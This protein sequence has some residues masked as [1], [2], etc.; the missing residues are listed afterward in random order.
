ME[1]KR[2]SGEVGR[3]FLEK[4]K[5]LFSERELKS[6]VPRDIAAWSRQACDEALPHRIADPCKNDWYGAG[7]LSHR[8]NARRTESEYHARRCA[9]QFRRESLDAPSVRTGPTIVDLQIAT[10][11]PTVL[12][13]ALPE[14]R[15]PSLRF[16]IV[17]GEAAKNAYASHPLGLLRARHQRPSRRPAYQ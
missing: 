16:W 11:A 1:E 14:C 10:L 5:P 13:H 6:R 7:Y 9:D 4:A 2:C 17:Y 15:D 12:L 8:R 3:Q